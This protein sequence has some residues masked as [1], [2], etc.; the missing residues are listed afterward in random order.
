MPGTRVA[1]LAGLLDWAT[2]PDS[3]PVFWLSGMA[4]TGKSSITGS[5]A[6]LLDGVGILGAS[7]FC[8]R[9]E[10]ERRD[11]KRIIPTLAHSLARCHPA[12]RSELLAMLDKDPDIGH[13][14]LKE[15]FSKL[16]VAPLVSC[17][18]N[19]VIII[20]ALDECEAPDATRALLAAFIR[21]KHLPI[22]ILFSSRPEPQMRENLDNPESNRILRLHDVEEDVVMR[23]I[24]LYLENRFAE[25]SRRRKLEHWPS[26]TDLEIVL[27]LCG[28]FFIYAFTVLEYISATGD[29]RRRLANLVA[30]STQTNRHYS[31][32]DQLYAFIM[33]SAFHGV[34]ADEQAAMRDMLSTIILLRSPL[35]LESIA[36][37]LGRKVHPEGELMSLHSVINI[38]SLRERPVSVFHASFADYMTDPSRSLQFFIDPAI[39]HTFL[40]TK[41]LQLMN[42]HLKHTDG[43]LFQPVDRHIYHSLAYSCVHWAAHLAA[44]SCTAQIVD[45]LQVFVNEHFLHWV[46]A[47]GWIGRLEDALASLHVASAALQV[48]VY[49]TSLSSGL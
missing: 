40:A 36:T 38:P 49:F 25:L 6:E 31:R 39:G 7:F 27:H 37:F 18:C 17:D 9:D 42:R 33:E 26:S 32:V 4:G 14:G 46:E 12:Y 30:S 34:E 44:G 23:D 22:K 41:S 45:L 29:S 13:Y 16:I 20:D 47:L 19:K 43:P 8:S 2:D 35:P 21:H 48:W 15:Q 5:A 1:I 3:P 24:R 10:A 11:V 28:A